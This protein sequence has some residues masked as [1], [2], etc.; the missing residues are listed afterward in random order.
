MSF[1]PIT[2]YI[3]LV[4]IGGLLAFDLLMNCSLEFHDFSNLAEGDDILVLI[5]GL[6]VIYVIVHESVDVN[7]PFLFYLDLILCSKFRYFLSFLCFSLGPI[8]F[9][10][11]CWEY[12]YLISN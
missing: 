11:V 9:E 5:I 6:E 8:Y 3:R 2:L 12:Y 7:H 4:V 1:S 10:L